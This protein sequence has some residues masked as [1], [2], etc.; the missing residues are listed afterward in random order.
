MH[1]VSWPVRHRF[2]SQHT[3][4][5]EGRLHASMRTRSPHSTHP[6]ARAERRA[7]AGRARTGGYRRARRAP[8]GSPLGVLRS[9]PATRPVRIAP[10][11]GRCGPRSRWRRSGSLPRQQKQNW[12]PLSAP[13]RQHPSTAQSSPSGGRPRRSAPRPALPHPLQRQGHGHHVQRFGAFLTGMIMPNLGI[14]HLGSDH[15]SV[16]LSRLAAQRHPRRLRQ[17][18]R[19]RRLAGRGHRAGHGGRRR[20]SSPSTSA[21][22]AR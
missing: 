2:T 6:R 3:D 12:A 20:D 9:V 4:V 17:R 19:R 21:S 5:F 18:R 8:V 13:A 7:S 22:S 1:R 14:H 11:W 15:V 16:R 10:G